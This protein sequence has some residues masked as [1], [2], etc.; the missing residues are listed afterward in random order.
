MEIT[1]EPSGVLPSGARFF[2]GS[3]RDL[4]W[5]VSVSKRKQGLGHLTILDVTTT[6][7]SL[8][9]SL[10]TLDKARLFVTSG[11]ALGESYAFAWASGYANGPNIRIQGELEHK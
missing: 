1:A 2:D 10:V 5:A 9:G 3:R 6:E 4:G 11:D 7:V 8:A